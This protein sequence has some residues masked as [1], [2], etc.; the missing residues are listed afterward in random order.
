MRPSIRGLEGPI[1]DGDLINV[2]CSAHFFSFDNVTFIWKVAGEQ[3]VTH[4]TEFN[5][6][7]NN[8]AS[9]SSVLQHKFRWEENKEKVW[10]ALQV[11]TGAGAVKEASTN[12]TANVYRKY[13]S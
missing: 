6:Y 8:T 3:F 5:R 9:F 12:V 2:T 11:W 4:L 13:M 7:E 1:K 10:C